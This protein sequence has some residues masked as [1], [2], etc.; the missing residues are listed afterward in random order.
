MNPLIL[1]LLALLCFFEIG[2]CSVAQAD[3][4][5]GMWL[6][7]KFISWPP[8]WFSLHRAGVT[9]LKHHVWLPSMFEAC[10]LSFAQ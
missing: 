3:V 4:E 10:M 5:L 8:I 9:G 7:I 6:R 2:P 1:V